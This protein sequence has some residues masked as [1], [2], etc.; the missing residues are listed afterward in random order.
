MNGIL[1]LWV[2]SGLR[3]AVALSFAMS[4]VASAQERIFAPPADQVAA[5][6][7]TVLERHCARCHQQGRLERA[8]PAAKFANVLQLGDLVRE[9]R[10]VTAGNADASRLWTHMM[11]KLM[12][13]DVYQERN[14]TVGPNAEE[15]LAVRDWIEHA[16]RPR[17][18][19]GFNSAKAKS[20]TSGAASS[21]PVLSVAANQASFARG[22]VLTL[23]ARS[24]VDCRVTL[25]S[26]D[27]RG[28]GTVLFPNE[29]ANN[30]ALAADQ[31]LVVPAPDAGYLFRVNEAG[32]ERV[33]ALCNMG[34]GA[35]DGIR[36]DFDRLRFTS[37]GD[38]RAF[39]AKAIASEAGE[40]GVSPKP[41][42]ARR[43]RVRQRPE[44]PPPEP[45]AAPQQVLRTG[46][47]IEVR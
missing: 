21:E 46:I 39:L 38:Y 42:P 8:T 2:R 13:Y 17:A 29:L 27:V 10:L 1:A 26:V 5:K 30:N 34:P 35:A 36:H 41:A 31:E 25:V 44:P 47:V 3:A 18:R 43:K 20:T 12:P 9:G 32:K 6:A 23:R 7:F 37:L 40:T 4:G 28:R 22:D 15:I 24:T 45:F 16:L 11:R 19:R 14:G 33:V